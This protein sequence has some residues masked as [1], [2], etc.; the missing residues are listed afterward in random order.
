MICL[1]CG[2]PLHNNEESGWH[3]SC[4]KKFFGTTQLPE[5][6]IDEK[7][8]DTFGVHIGKSMAKLCKNQIQTATAPKQPAPQR[9]LL[10]GLCC[11]FLPVRC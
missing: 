2:K 6:Q 8:L 5:I 1:C 10:S 11:V 3:K 9:A 7:S 4:I